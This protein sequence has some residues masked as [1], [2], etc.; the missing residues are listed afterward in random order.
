MMPSEIWAKAGGAAVRPAARTRATMRAM[1]MRQLLVRVWIGC[2][3]GSLYPEVLVQLVHA[4]GQVGVGD[5]IDHPAML[6]HVV[7][8]GHGGGEAEV[9]LDEQDGEAFRLQ[10]RDGR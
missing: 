4:G 1:V 9:L 8:I 10:A 6:H 3:R 2:R 7:A 5:G